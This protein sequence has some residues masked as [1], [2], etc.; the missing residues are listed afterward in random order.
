VAIGGN[1]DA[2]FRRFM[3]AIGRPDLAA[4]PGLADNAGRDGRRDEIYGA[5]DVWCAAH[6][7][8]E[9][10]A[11]LEAAQ[12]PASRVY[13][14][15]DMFADPQFLAREMIQTALR[16]DGKPLKVPG[17][18]PKLSATPGSTEWLGPALGEHTDSILAALGY[19]AEDIAALR[20][21]LAKS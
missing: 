3:A 12:V 5:V 18:V 17:I 15:A 2:I 21:E 11:A 19:G 7:E 4:D 9:V 14:A 20:A 6:D 1:G 16:A 13:S 8:A 10:L